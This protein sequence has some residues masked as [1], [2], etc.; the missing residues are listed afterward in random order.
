[1]C[2]AALLIALGLAYAFRVRLL[3][4][5]VNSRLPRGEGEF[6]VED[7]D[8]NLLG[9]V[10]L[11]R[12]SWTAKDPRAP[13]QRCEIG[14][15]EARYSLW[16]LLHGELDG[17]ASVTAR[18]FDVRVDLLH[19]RET[20][21]ID[22]VWP[23]RLPELSCTGGSFQLLLASGTE[24]AGK[25]LALSGG[26]TAFEIAGDELRVDDPRL[27]GRSGAL[28]MDGTYDAGRFAIRSLELDGAQV[29]HDSKLDLARVAQ[30]EL[31]F[32]LELALFRGQA[33]LAG[34]W[35]A[36]ALD[37]DC[38]LRELDLESAWRFLRPA[39]QQPPRASIDAQGKL[40]WDLAEDKS[41]GLPEVSLAGTARSIAVGGHLFETL[42]TQLALR[43]DALEISRLLLVQGKNRL[44]ARDA[45]I[46]LGSRDPWTLLR[47][48]RGEVDLEWLDVPALIE[49]SER[50]AAKVPEHRLRIS[51]SLLQDRAELRAG[52]L[53]T[54]GGHFT[55]R[56]GLLTWG[57][58][59]DARPA[60]TQLDL[61]LEL[62]FADLSTVS[63]LWGEADWSGSLRGSAHVSGTARAP[64]GR[65]DLRGTGVVIAGLAVGEV[66]LAAQ[67]DSQRVE[68]APSVAR[69]G[70]GELRFSGGLR[71]PDLELE[72][73]QL[74]FS[75]SALA[76]LAPGAFESG[77]VAVEA[78]ASGPWR[79][80]RARFVV[81][82]QQLSFHGRPLESLSARGTVEGSEIRLDELRAR[83]ERIAI[84]GRGSLTH[85]EWRPP[86]TLRMEELRA[87]RD[88]LDLALQE[89]VV[90]QL[91]RGR[92]SVEKL[93]CAGTA[94]VLA[95]ELALS[96]DDVRVHATAQDLRAMQ[97]LGPFLPQGLFLEGV[98]GE[99]SLERKQAALTVDAALDVERLRFQDLQ[100]E[101]QLHAHLRFADGRL[102]AEQLV[103]DAP[104]RA[105]LSLQGSVPFDPFGP[106]LLPEG[107]LSFEGK[108]DLAQLSDVPWL[109]L[110]VR[111]EWR[112]RASSAFKLGGSWSA[113]T[114][115]LDYDANLELPDAASGLPGME[116]A[117]RTVQLDLL[118]T[119]GRAIL[120]DGVRLEALRLEAADR[121]LLTATGTVHLPA[122][123]HAW[124]GGRVPD[125]RAAAVSMQGELT[126]R[127]LSFLAALTPSLRRVGGS[128]DGRLAMEGTLSE[129]RLTG[130][131]S[132]HQ[133]EL[134][135]NTRVPAL[136]NLEAELT[137]D[138]NRILVQSLA[139]EFGAAPFSIAGTIAL[140]EG[141]PQ[142]D[143]TVK[144]EQILLV[145]A[146]G[147]RIR[148]DADLR[149]A[150]PYEHLKW[151]GLLDLRDARYT[152]DFDFL[153][154]SRGG[155]PKP[156]GR[157]ELF[158]LRQPPWSG[159]EF[160][161]DVRASEP[162]AVENNLARGRLRPDLRLV[163]TGPAPELLGTVF[164]DPA[165]VR[166]PVCILRLSSG[167]MTFASTDP[168]VPQLDLHAE[169]RVRGYDISVN[170]SGPPNE[171]T[172][173]LTSVPPLSHEELVVLVLTGQLPEQALSQKGGEQAA[174]TVAVF[175]G[176]D[177][178]TSWFGR[179]SEDGDEALLERL[180]VQRGTDVSKAGVETTQVSLR[181]SGDE[182]R[183]R[184]V[185]YLGAEK[186]VYER[187]NF[188]VKFLFRIE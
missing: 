179:G 102:A 54:A 127:D 46:P 161:V 152:R 21:P 113:L 67:A 75:S 65:F 188:G 117:W 20:P 185:I 78:E 85:R 159:M 5:L 182:R 27:G 45:R 3:T 34:G 4:S 175:V 136:E 25:G 23:A 28:A 62:D 50:F 120:G 19:K 39:E 59:P 51:A 172:V 166:L 49:G 53:E 142:F 79:E 130:S 76:Q 187:I 115:E 55:V 103:L 1:V 121:A 156:D 114:G 60:D 177:L 150:G 17:L 84:E 95:G 123:V 13:L 176:Q 155:G 141:Q 56:R 26:G 181:L 146:S 30:G 173:L 12:V 70:L 168:N 169:T 88:E 2:G 148:A 138:K 86:V 167:T 99:L 24:L 16:K 124:I 33:S 91:D 157:L 119:S 106:E 64:S 131:L 92:V 73:M 47:N 90:V 140:E 37:F 9:R 178:I 149:L 104:G 129:P 126:A 109:A 180:E 52:E 40:H 89:P 145:R 134:R 22:W 18:D 135:T 87:S 80:P 137:F 107:E 68:F 101:G 139:G 133:G 14:S 43:S 132:V 171:P 57:A 63:A 74:S 112:G 29:L 11:R 32:E 163:G 48:S 165:R 154:A 35:R 8:G 98:K 31:S 100:P 184:R 10:H 44:E 105:T 81:E 41:A 186:D 162:F 158:S 6:A 69:G 71:L 151:T 122:D 147:L 72:A 38:D 170:V 111:T 108:F 66:E 144:G 164:V 83:L 97:L 82:A 77:T 125:W 128:L 42:E 58:G 7:I 183:T 118:H 61:D 15:L 116:D 96:G 153:G 143:L 94:G 36:G 174:E 93:R 110:G 160:D